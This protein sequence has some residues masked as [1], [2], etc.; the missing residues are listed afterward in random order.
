MTIFEFIANK[1]NKQPKY[2]VTEEKLKQILQQEIE[3]FFPKTGDWAL[4]C[5]DR[6]ESVD[7]KNLPC[8]LRD[9]NWLS[10]YMQQLLDRKGINAPLNQIAEFLENSKRF[11]EL[12][13]NYE[14]EIVRWQIEWM[15]SGGMGWLMPEG[16]G[17]ISLLIGTSVDRMIRGG[18]VKTL[19]AIGL[20]RE[21]IEEG[22]E[23]NANL[24]RDKYMDLSFE[25]RFNP[26]VYGKGS[27]EIAPSEEHRANWKKLR[28]YEYYLAHGDSIRKYG[29]VT[30]DM[31]MTKEK[32]KALDVSVRRQNAERSLYVDEWENRIMKY[33]RSQDDVM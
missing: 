4:S 1:K 21:A 2:N 11:A 14:L 10:K 6:P 33:K 29:E 28:T 20:D 24:W 9:N 27:P 16:Y 30:S 26:M 22:I 23:K 13:H 17:P 5:Y 32:A 31:L 7:G 8:H 18:I 12:R 25:H 19:S 15:N 3:R